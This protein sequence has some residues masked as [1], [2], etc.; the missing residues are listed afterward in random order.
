MLRCPC[1]SRWGHTSCQPK[2]TSIPAEACRSW[3]PYVL[4]SV[5]QDITRP[6]LLIN[7]QLKLGFRLWFCLE[8]FSYIATFICLRS[9]RLVRPSRH[10]IGTPSCEINPIQHILNFEIAWLL[11]SCM[12]FDLL[13]G[14]ILRGQVDRAVGSVD[15]AVELVQRLP[16]ISVVYGSFCTVGSQIVSVKS[17]SKIVVIL[18]HRKIGPQFTSSGISFQVHR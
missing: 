11:F 15:N 17:H 6:L 7:S 1:T 12:F 3:T 13:A 16:W 10:P 9:Q 18:S 5:N 14:K 8:K 4:H 2:E